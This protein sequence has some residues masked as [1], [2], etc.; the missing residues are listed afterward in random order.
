L[1]APNILL[2][3][4]DV[5][6]GYGGG[7]IISNISVDVEE[8][9][10]FTV[11]GPNGSGKS[12]LIKVLAGLLRAR[13]GGITIKEEQ[14][15]PLAAP[16]R[17]AKGIAYVPQE[18]NVFANLTIDENLRLSTEFLKRDRRATGEQRGRVLDMFPEIA[19]RLSL[20]AGH[21]SGGQRQM[22]AFACA[23]MAAPVVLL[24][25]EPSAG[26]SPK[27]VTEIFDRIKAVNETGLTVVMIEQNVK[28]AL[29]IA[30]TVMV[31]VGG[32][33][34]LFVPASEIGST[35]DLHKLFLG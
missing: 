21:L 9:K 5:A 2:R 35:H 32:A 27:F 4:K 13:V 18:Y 30:D 10:I 34:R 20:R 31:L 28:E 33:T 14:I 6:A 23:M 16:E 7:D 8:G 3:T 29:R 24:L 17:V 12:T 25:D 19:T 11:I 15:A 1:S 26:L 22:L